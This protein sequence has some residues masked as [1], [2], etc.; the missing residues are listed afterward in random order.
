M[1]NPGKKAI[2]ER[3]QGKGDETLGR[4]IEIEFKNLLTKEDFAL[5]L[6]VFYITEADFA[7]QVNHYFDTDTFLLKQS[8]AALR[9]RKEDNFYELTLKKTAPVGLLE[10]NQTISAAEANVC[11]QQLQF[12]EG[13][14]MEEL[15]AMN[16]EPKRLVCFGSLET[17]RAKRNFGPGCLMFDH[18]RYM[19]RE[20]FEVEYEVPEAKL[21]EG[22]KH[23]F[24]LLKRLNIPVKK[25]DSKIKRLFDAKYTC[26]E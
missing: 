1:N 25:A 8:T 3:R 2:I 23:F 15:A 5:L 21:N 19:G 10:I 17:R 7:K 20:D 18:S 12:P 26:L 9:I 13:E 22:Q 6:N 14:V 24:Q 4:N 11:I 16:I